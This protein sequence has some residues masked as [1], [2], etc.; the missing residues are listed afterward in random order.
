M[1]TT[2][3]PLAGPR[4]SCGGSSSSPAAG[5]FSPAGGAL[6]GLPRRRR[7]S[8][9]AARAVLYGEHLEVGQS[10]LAMTAEEADAVLTEPGKKRAARLVAL[11]NGWPA[12]IGLPPPTPP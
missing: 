4:S 5:L 12:V 11:A 6:L 9:S 7:A 3:Y 10:S 8:G 2:Q 1:T